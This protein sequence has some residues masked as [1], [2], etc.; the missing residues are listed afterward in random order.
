MTIAIG[1]GHFTDSTRIKTTSVAGQRSRRRR[2]SRPS[3]PSSCG[4]GEPRREGGLGHAGPSHAEDCIDDGIFVIAAA[5]DRPHGR[6]IEPAAGDEAII[7]MHA[8]HLAEYDVTVDGIAGDVLER[9]CLSCVIDFTDVFRI[10]GPVSTSAPTSLFFPRSRV[11][12]RFDQWRRARKFGEHG[13][14]HSG[15]VH[16]VACLVSTIIFADSAHCSKPV[17]AS[18]RVLQSGREKG[19]RQGVVMVVVKGLPLS[20]P[21][22]IRLL[23]RLGTGMERGKKR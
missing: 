4:F 11:Y 19:C 14:Q 3:R 1:C 8:D 13:W 9:H 5:G 17:I 22:A 12:S 10:F 18:A 21:G 15:H 7:D 20:R 2:R 6:G 16:S 23:V